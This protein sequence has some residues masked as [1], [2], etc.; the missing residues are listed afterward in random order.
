MRN[1]LAMSA[2][3]GAL[4]S[5][6][7]VAYLSERAAGGVGLI[8]VG[9]ANAGVAEYGPLRGL[10]EPGGSVAFDT[11]GPNPATAAGIAYYDDIVIPMLRG[12]AEAVHAGGA[13]GFGQV[14][15]L[16]SYREVDHLGVG[17]G[18]SAGPDPDGFGST[19]ELTG[20][21]IEELVVT[22]AAAV[23]R[24]QRAGLDGAE[25]HAAH[26]FLV[27]AF[28]DPQTNRRADEWGGDLVGRARFLT[29][30]V[31]AARELVGP[32]FP[33]GLR[34]GAG[35]TVSTVDIIEL[36]RM[37]ER[38]LAYVSVSGGTVSG[39]RGGLPY[40]STRFD[41]AGHNLAV[42]AELKRAVAVPILAAGRILTPERAAAA[43]L[44]E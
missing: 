33:L 15:H 24:C 22:Y 3:N 21:E 29:R 32:D 12:R 36:V 5:D 28:L 34:V 16:G 10:W 27:N 44:A 25:L 11:V 4:P 2:H 35:P 7:Y 17:I 1:R 42:A 13:L 30:V 38:D 20:G 41:P 31:A 43:V 26:G 14:F 8:V 19:Y 23:H 37:L 6:R 39:A 40:A 9:G 18:P